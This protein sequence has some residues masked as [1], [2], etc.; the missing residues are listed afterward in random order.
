MEIKRGFAWPQL[1]MAIGASVVTLTA[2]AQ[3]PQ[4]WPSHPITWVVGYAPGGSTDVVARTIAKKVSEDL[5]QPIVVQNRP[6]ANSNIGAV[7]VLRAGSDGY[8]LYVGSGANAIN[9]TLYSN[10]G[11]DIAKDFSAVALFGTVSNLLVVNPDLPVR[12]VGEYIE[13]AKKNPG[14][15]TCG[16]SGPGSSIHMSCELFK[17]ETG[18]DIMHVPFNGSGPAMTALLGGQV[19]SI[20]ENMPTVMPNV[21]AGKLRALGVTSP[22][23]WLTAP[24]IPTLRESG[25]PN[26]SV[27][28][29]F[30]L[31]APAQTNSDIVTKMNKAINVALQDASTRDVLT[32][33]GLQVPPQPNPPGEFAQRVK[34]DVEKWATVV[35]QSGA[36]AD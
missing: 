8:T 15:L 7:S 33:R 20:F 11:Y 28:T 14:K 18:T 29:W 5:G 21:Q 27:V 34:A 35:R 1:C 23:R 25:V 30:G 19:D 24:D 10:P 22:D 2:S 4:E 31:F 9:R 36:K 32:Q 16:S 26:F 6:G 17:I 13:Y 3:S 12:T